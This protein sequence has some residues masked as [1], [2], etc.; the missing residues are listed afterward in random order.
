M[1]DGE[2]QENHRRQPHFEQG[3]A[4]F[5]SCTSHIYRP[6]CVQF[7]VQELQIMLIGTCEFY[8]S[9]QRE[10]L[11]FWWVQKKLDLCA[12]CGTTRHFENKWKKPCKICV[13][14]H[15]VHNLVVCGY[16]L[17]PTCRCEATECNMLVRG[18]GVQPVGARLRSATCRC[19][20]TEYNM[21]VRGYGVQHVGVRL[22]SATCLCEATE[23]NITKL[24]DHLDRAGVV[25]RLQ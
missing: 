22:R 23:C 25:I 10:D 2:L 3:C 19:E 6:I 14:G 20:A 17:G 12:P 5:A 18:Y 24:G 11:N 16:F 21:S 7:G 8:V 1:C 9:Q 4:R 15:R 13:L